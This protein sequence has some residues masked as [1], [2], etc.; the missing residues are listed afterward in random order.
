MIDLKLIARRVADGEITVGS[1]AVEYNLNASQLNSLKDLVAD[2]A[3]NVKEELIESMKSQPELYHPPVMR[4]LLDGGLSADNCEGMPRPVQR[5]VLRGETLTWDD[6]L[7][8]GVVTAAMTPEK[9]TADEDGRLP[10]Y[11]IRE[12]DGEIVGRHRTDVFLLGVAGCGKSSLAC[13]LIKQLIDGCGYEY[14]PMTDSEDYAKTQEYYTGVMEV[15]RDFQKPV[16]PSLDDN[17]LFLQLRDTHSRRRLTVIDGDS[18][19]MADVSKILTDDSGTVRNDTV[20]RIMR[21]DNSKILLFLIDYG[22][23]KNRRKRNLFKQSMMMESVI[24]TL[25]SDGDS[26]DG[27][28]NCTFSRVKGVAFVVTK[29]DSVNDDALNLINAFFDE[30]MKTVM[31]R[32]EHVNATFGINKD[33][34]FRPYLVPVSLGNFT[35]GNTF[36]YNPRTSLQLAQLVARLTPTQWPWN[37]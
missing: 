10:V 16:A 32:L 15:T 22:I 28:K 2:A 17:L 25:T 30:Q 14:Q 19:V 35:V 24:N 13:S 36:T 31:M 37:C 34:G 21:N 23:I 27:K 20:Y 8:A 29:C 11:S 7:E 18:S 6:L 33:N 26:A 12:Y 5:L 3:T 4:L 9:V 1:A